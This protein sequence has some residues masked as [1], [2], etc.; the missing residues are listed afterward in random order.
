MSQTFDAI[1]LANIIIAD[2]CDWNWDCCCVDI[3]Q[4]E[5]RPLASVIEPFLP[6]PD[7]AVLGA[8]HKAVYAAHAA[9]TDRLCVGN[10]T[11]YA[12]A[13]FRTNLRKA[14]QRP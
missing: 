7:R 6:L 8:W 14:H 13:C 3:N 10:A 12:I 9:K 2:E 4:L 1:R 11:A 5:T